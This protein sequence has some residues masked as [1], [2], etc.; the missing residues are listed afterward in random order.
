MLR[1]SPLR[2]RGSSSFLAANVATATILG[3]LVTATTADYMWVGAVPLW[4]GLG[5]IGVLSAFSV[6]YIRGVKQAAPVIVAWLTF[7]ALVGLIDLCR[8]QLALTAL[9]QLAFGAGSLAAFVAAVTY[10]GLAGP[11]RVFTV[12]LIV[13]S[14][15]GAVAIGQM[16]G[17]DTAVR[18]PEAIADTWPLDRRLDDGNAA[19]P[20]TTSRA[21]GTALLVHKFAAFQ[22]IETC[23]VLL[24]FLGGLSLPTV[25]GGRHSTGLL[26]LVALGGGA[27]T[28]SRS[29][30]VGILLALSVYLARPR[31]GTHRS[32][33]VR[34]LAIVVGSLAMAHFIGFWDTA[35]VSRLMET[36]G[37]NDLIRLQTWSFAAET[38]LANP[39]FGSGHIGVSPGVDAS[40]HSVPLRIA[41]SYGIAGFVPY[42]SA[43]L[44]L[45]V[46]LIRR[47]KQS[48][49]HGIAAIAAL[50]GWLVA[51]ADSTSHSS[52]FFMYDA[53]QPVLLG[54]MLGASSSLTAATPLQLPYLVR[55]S[56]WSALRRACL[57][58]RTGDSDRPPSY[59]SGRTP[60]ARSVR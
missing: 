6:G 60:A 17:V 26:V 2:S 33:L 5:A 29:I 38:F 36:R 46:L 47:S 18:I 1:S 53:A 32:S 56:M 14:V 19:P 8:G 25:F 23:F 44:S 13:A 39:F 28:F 52:G 51:V 57:C 37:Q 55:T 49:E 22:G 24:C 35:T 9:P 58:S 3:L 27:A 50:G 59:G 34:M 40:I 11:R 41:A 12:V 20:T 43:V 15:Q 45:L 21:R 16:L 30:I 42:V 54:S 7:L 4:A 31:R 48:N 10:G